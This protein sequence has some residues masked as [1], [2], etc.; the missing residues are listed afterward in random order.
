[1][2]GVH[3][4]D[5]YL[6]DRLR[7]FMSK[8]TET[9]KENWKIERLKTDKIYGIQ[10]EESKFDSVNFICLLVIRVCSIL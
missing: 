9:L 2:V 8:N 6:R 1:M 5:L 7:Q 10:S 4:F 3:D